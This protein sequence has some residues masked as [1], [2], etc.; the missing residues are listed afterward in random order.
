MD[1]H[2]GS[3]KSFKLREL[4]IQSEWDGGNGGVAITGT[5]GRFVVVGYR[6][7]PSNSNSIPNLCVRLLLKAAELEIN[8]PDSTHG[9]TLILL[10]PDVNTVLM[11]PE[12]VETWH[13]TWH[14]AGQNSQT[15]ALLPL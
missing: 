1:R 9:Q 8:I 14:A 5:E 13:E 3:A 7:T 10:S 15:G 2:R 12:T 6:S 4:R 11:V